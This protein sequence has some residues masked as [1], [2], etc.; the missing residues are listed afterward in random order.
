MPSKRKIVIAFAMVGAL[1]VALFVLMDM[2]NGEVPELTTPYLRYIGNELL[3]SMSTTGLISLSVLTI[4]V[5]ILEKY[6]PW[7]ENLWRRVVTEFFLTEAVAMVSMVLIILL[8]IFVG[9]HDFTVGSEAF[10]THLKTQLFVTFVMNLFLVTVYE[11]IVLFTHWKE[12]L[13]LNEKL[14]KESIASKFEALQN[15]VNPHFLFNS[16]NTLSNLVHEDANRA[17]DFI[18]EFSHV[19]RYVLETK[20]QMVTSVQEE[21]EF[22]R[23]YLKLCKI[24]FGEALQSDIQLDINQLEQLIPTLALQT[25]VENAIKHNRI[26]KKDPLHISIYNEGDNL[27]VQNNF[28][29]LPEKPASTGIGLQNITD[30]YHLLSEAEPCFRLQNEHYVAKL[31]LIKAS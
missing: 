16:L 25:L 26:T 24:R 5:P 2:A 11:G 31:P 13:I 30:R 14:E 1:P 21:V 18:D 3:V 6:V 23:S 28:Q 12:S 17:E 9:Y 7:D 22:V 15:Q 27:V 20:D 19:Y 4:A 29:P 10:W 8:Y